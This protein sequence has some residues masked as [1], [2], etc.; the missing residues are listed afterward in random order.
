VEILEYRVRLVNQDSVEVEN[1]LN[2]HK[3][4]LRCMKIVDPIWNPVDIHQDLTNEIFSDKFNEKF[5]LIGGIN[6][7]KPC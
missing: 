4:P 5:N 7:L 3:P 6:H 2:L 1:M